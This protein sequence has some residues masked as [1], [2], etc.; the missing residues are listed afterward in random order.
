MRRHTRTLY[1]VDP[2]YLHAPLWKK[3]DS[4][5]SSVDAFINIIRIYKDEIEA[6]RVIPVMD[7]SQFFLKKFDDRH[8]DW[9]YLDSSHKYE[10]TIQEIQLCLTKIK[11]GGYLLGDDYDPD[12]ASK[13]YG[14]FKAVNETCERLGVELAINE[15]RQWGICI[16]GAVG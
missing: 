13:Q 2:W 6:G 7:Y 16:P 4:A 10:D 15:A 11:P 8:F 9:L 1:L 5:S 14:V 12:P 3:G